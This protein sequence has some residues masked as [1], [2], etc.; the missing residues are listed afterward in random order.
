VT[1][2]SALSDRLTRRLFCAGLFALAIQAGAEPMVL[3]YPPALL[4]G[5]ISIADESG[6]F[7]AQG[8]DVKLIKLPTGDDGLSAI[9]EGRVSAYAVGA[10]TFT[11]HITRN[12]DLRVIS[13]IGE[14]GNETRLA[15]LA[16]SGIESPDDLRN[17]RVASQYGSSFHYFRDLLLA[18]SGLTEA[19]IRPVF[20]HM[21][22]QPAALAKGDI[23]AAI[24]REP[25]IGQA[26]RLLG[27]QLRILSV[28]GLLIKRFILV[29]N[30]QTLAA[31]EDCMVRLL[32]ALAT[33]E[34]IVRKK[35]VES[36]EVL[37]M[38]KL[39]VPPLIESSLTR[40]RLQIGVDN[41]LLYTLEKAYPWWIRVD[42][43][44]DPPEIDFLDIIVSSPLMLAKPES[45]L[46]RH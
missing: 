4:T 36:A 37:T 30:R 44:N 24:L 40:M 38:Q 43:I 34:G 45:V 1:K 3:G 28:P 46:L 16:G 12:P 35:P 22:K 17:R 32:K 31:C 6:A 39:G 9:N 29:T 21:K 13:S 14:W 11:K 10:V 26:Q 2:W 42:G 27:D 8:L 41:H 33:A 7:E 18:R 15:V 20:L 23:D 19:D 25:Y 5:L